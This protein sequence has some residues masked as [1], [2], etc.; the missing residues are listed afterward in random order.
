MTIAFELDHGQK[1]LLIATIA[2]FASF[3]A[4]AYS[5]ENHASQH[6][7]NV[8]PIRLPQQDGGQDSSH[9]QQMQHTRDQP[10]SGSSCRSSRFRE[11][12]KFTLLPVEIRE[13]IYEHAMRQ[14]STF[15]LPIVPTSSARP[16]KHSVLTQCVPALCYTSRNERAIGISVFVRNASFQLYRE[17][18][19]GVLA[20]WLELMSSGH[21]F[22]SIRKMEICHSP[23]TRLKG[24]R[25]DIDLLKRCPGLREITIMLPLEELYSV[26]QAVVDGRMGIVVMRA[27]T[28]SGVLAKFEL[29]ALLDCESLRKIN[30]RLSG[31]S[32]FVLW[33][34]TRAL[35]RYNDLQLLLAWMAKGFE[36]RYGRPVEMSMAAMSEKGQVFHRVVVK[37]R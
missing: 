9:R 35:H 22:R 33:W 12:H 30:F 4:A 14:G 36:I 37:S 26:K 10:R 1:S 8:Q 3:A 13:I 21:D 27:L 28:G 29:G 19:A 20:C 31:N 5:N 6:A 16:E 18:D 23:Q 25:N 15:T 2:I 17:G 11:F 32:R 7:A 34:Y 24:L